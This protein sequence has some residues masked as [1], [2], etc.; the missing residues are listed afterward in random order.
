MVFH[1]GSYWYHF[2]CP[3]SFEPCE[4]PGHGQIKNTYIPHNH[5]S[6]IQE[7][8]SFLRICYIYSD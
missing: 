6:I 1:T 2:S 5:I 4:K 7:H 3:G 8:G